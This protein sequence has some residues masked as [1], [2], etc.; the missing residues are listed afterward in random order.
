MSLEKQIIGSGIQF[1]A[2]KLL[3]RGKFQKVNPIDKYIS[4]GGITGGG[5][6]KTTKGPTT[7]GGIAK[8]GIM[9]LIARSILGP[10]LGPLAL[11]IGTSIFNK[12]PNITKGLGF[13]N[14]DGV[15]KGPGIPKGPFIDPDTPSDEGFQVTGTYGGNDFYSAEGTTVDEETGDLTNADGTYG[16]NIVDEFA[17]PSPPSNNDS[18]G[19]SGGGGQSDSQAGADASQS[20][21]DEDAGAGGYA[22]GGRAS[23][24]GGGLA[25]LYR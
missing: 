21:S 25:S 23:Y 16:G 9:S 2:N 13:F 5:T 18:D 8:Q 20:A 19:D 3:N 10:I 1:A 6:G 4:G 17:Q 22:Y 24:S 15:P 12:N 11:T 14:Q 7:I